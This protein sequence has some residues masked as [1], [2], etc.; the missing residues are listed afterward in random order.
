MPSQLHLH[1]VAR[2]AM[3][4]LTD[5]VLL[6]A[7]MLPLILIPQS[8]ALG[9]DADAVPF[10]HDQVIELARQLSRAPAGK[11]SPVTPGLDKLTYD[12][13]R[14]LRF[15]VDKAVWSDVDSPFRLDLL[16]AGFVYQTPVSVS[17]V[18][19]GQASDLLSD[20]SMWEIG[21][22][23]PAALHNVS[24]SLSGFR[25]RTRLNSRSYW[26]EFLVFQGAS[27]F[28]AVGSGQLYG[29]SARG[30]ALRTGEPSGEEFPAFTHFW[31]ERPVARSPTITIHALLE[32]TSITGAYQFVVKPGRDTTIDVEF[33]LFPRVDLNVVGI[34]PL[35]S[36]FL[37]D[38]SNRGRFEDFRN[39]VHDS[40]GLSIEADNG[41]WLWRPLANPRQLQ[42]S[43]FTSAAPRRFGLVQRARLPG[44]YQDLE[45]SYERRPSAWV[46]PLGTW[47]PGPVRLIEIPSLLETNDNIVS[48]WQPRGG[49][50]AG[51]VYRGAYR[52]HWSADLQPPKG[53][54][55]VVATRIGA[56]FD[57]K[58]KLFVVDV[59]GAGTNSEGLKV[60]V[61]NNAGKVSNAVIQP[62]PMIK[63][64]RASFELD[65]SDAQM[66]ELRLVVMKD[67]RAVSETWLY[68][69]TAS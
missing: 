39:A 50:A 53:L 64:L 52:L 65:P 19:S 44:D 13:Y 15:R 16:P 2:A 32:S 62:N 40:D 54:G 20:P 22:K 69:W 23:V 37:F 14:E 41:E 21:P 25:V 4:V 45:A 26:D 31:I 59:T 57:G 27:Y 43:S 67:Q 48:F 33:A 38:A 5:R 63:G 34:A 56:S 36:M 11:P 18:E 30:L 7:A 60:V 10:S 12:Q 17:L 46:E 42:F 61:S 1:R 24:L 51:R 66:V 47:R 35:T 49:L 3:S 58:R 55:R 6:V 29:L 68:R 9:A 8:P 28:R